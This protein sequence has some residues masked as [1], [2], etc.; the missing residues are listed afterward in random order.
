MFTYR[1]RIAT[2]TQSE[3]RKPTPEEIE[4]EIPT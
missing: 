3:V 1:P 2:P 4:E